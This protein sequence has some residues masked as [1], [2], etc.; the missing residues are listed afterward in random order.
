MAKNTRSGLG[1]GLNS[2]MGGYEAPAEASSRKKSEQLEN[3]SSEAAP[4]VKKAVE[5][6]PRRSVEREVVG[7]RTSRKRIGLS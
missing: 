4:E 1:R 3:L 7:K 6:L 2:L 5:E